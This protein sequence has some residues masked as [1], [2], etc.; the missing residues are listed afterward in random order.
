MASGVGWVWGLLGVQPGVGATMGGPIPAIFM[1]GTWFVE[2]VAVGGDLSAPWR[3]M[4]ARH[5]RI[6]SSKLS[7]S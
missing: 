7:F 1:V 5:A 4:E 3:P 6:C 2:N